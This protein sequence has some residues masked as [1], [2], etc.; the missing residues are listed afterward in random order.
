MLISNES[1]YWYKDAFFCCVFGAREKEFCKVM[2]DPNSCMFEYID[3]VQTVA[4]MVTMTA[5]AQ[6]STLQ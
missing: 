2:D 1:S 3:D 4:G 6:T 5:S